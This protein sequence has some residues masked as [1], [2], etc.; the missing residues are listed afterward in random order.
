[1]TNQLTALYLSL[2]R[3]IDPLRSRLS[4]LEGMEFL[5][6]RYGWRI[7]LDDLV[8]AKINDLLQIQAPIEQFLELA[9]RLES[10][11]EA[12]P[13]TSLGIEDG[14]DIARSATRLVRALADFKL[15]ALADLPAPLADQEFWRSI[16]DHLLDDLLEE[17]LRLYHPVAYGGLHFWLS[18][19]HI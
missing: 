11:L 10:A 12:D 15:S 19:I 18:L 2:K 5:F 16:G 13:E 6:H 4:S 14:A 9:E 8:F 3:V 17:Y 7:T 1:M